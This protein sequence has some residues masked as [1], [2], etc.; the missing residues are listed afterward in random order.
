MINQPPFPIVIYVLPSSCTGGNV[1]IIP[2]SK[3]FK[4]WDFIHYSV[5]RTSATTDDKT[6]KTTTTTT[7]RT[8][9][10]VQTTISEGK[11]TASGHWTVDF[12][13]AN[14]MMK[15]VASDGVV[16]KVLQALGVDCS[17][18]EYDEDTDCFQITP[19]NKEDAVQ[20]VLVTSCPLPTRTGQP[21]GTTIKYN[22]QNLVVV[23]RSDVEQWGIVFKE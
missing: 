16:S 2:E 11:P 18:I 23:H 13:H 14:A 6:A 3:S 1:I 4:A 5:S 15:S 19:R 12:K 22:F 10:F 21:D 7:K 9:T 17:K 20:F 8:V